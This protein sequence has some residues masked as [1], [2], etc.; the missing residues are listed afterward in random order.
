MIAALMASVG[1]LAFVTSHPKSPVDWVGVLLLGL[2]FAGLPIA[3]L[4]SMPYQFKRI[5]KQFHLLRNGQIGIGVVEDIWQTQHASTFRLARW[6]ATLRIVSTDPPLT[7]TTANAGRALQTGCA[8][9]LF[10]DPH[11][12]QSLVPLTDITTSGLLA[13]IKPASASEIVLLCLGWLILFGF[14]SLAPLMWWQMLIM[15]K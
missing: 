4:I 13:C 6:E 10:Y 14:A 12:P 9:A 7:I 3:A 5:G 15:P 11:D 2:V 1:Y 8:C